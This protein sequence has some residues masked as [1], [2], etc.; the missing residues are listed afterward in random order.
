MKHLFIYKNKSITLIAADNTVYVN[1]KEMGFVG[2]RSAGEY[3]S[4]GKTKE[5]ITELKVLNPVT[6]KI[7]GDN[8]GTWLH[9][10]VALDFAA[11]L[12]PEFQ[13]WLLRIINGILPKPKKVVKQKVETPIFKVSYTFSYE[14]KSCYTA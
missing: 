6:E 2:G 7:N 11:W 10:D 13:T 3:L 9:K 1:G 4:R 14:L 12:S 8:I 5:F